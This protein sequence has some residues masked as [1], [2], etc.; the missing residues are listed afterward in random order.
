[1]TGPVQESSLLSGPLLRSVVRVAAPA[2]AFQL[3]IFL[4]NFVDYQWVQQLGPEAAAG[5]TAAWT[6]FWMLLNMGQVFSIGVT[7]VIARRIGEG[8][9][10]AALHAAT[11]GMRGALIASVVVGLVGWILA[12]HLVGLL[13][14]SPRATGYAT[15]YLQAAAAGAPLY[16]CFYSVEGA[17]KGRGDMRT[18]L[19][20]VA[21]ALG[22]NMV[23]DPLLIH[24][25]GLEVLGAALATVLSFGITA[26][27]LVWSGERRGWVRL[28]GRGLDL[29]VVKR[30]VRIGAPLSV[31]GILF[32]FVYLVINREVNRAGGDAAGAALGL[33]LRIEG[34]AYMTGVGLAA[35]AA[36]LVGQNL[37]AGQPRRAHD[38]AW[39][40]VRLGVWITGCYGLAMLI[41]PIGL[42]TWL[43]PDSV[44]ASHA[45][46]YLRIVSIAVAFTAVEII[47]QGAFS[48][49][50]D[51]VAPMLLGVP[52]TVVRVPLAMFA[53]PR[54]GVAGIFW[55]LAVTAVIRGL[56]FAFWFSRGRWVDAKA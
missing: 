42:V 33:G 51:T 8:K 48:G 20:A 27:L 13:A 6:I 2:M 22:L 32:S 19:R 37:G 26:A 14:L 56:G 52:L 16:F 50:G 25:M 45:Q 39:T 9:E 5:Q 12:P 46:D 30:I 34:F 17:F 4:N 54:W 28:S 41:A 38:A 10:A 31:H 23:F 18:P 44:T 1:L 55:V 3:L 15:D 7:A 11:H 35:G 29:L 43:S 40:S 36:A 49:A 53:G 24:F 21:M 47:L